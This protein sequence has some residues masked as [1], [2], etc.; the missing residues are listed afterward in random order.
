MGALSVNSKSLARFFAGSVLAVILAAAPIELSAKQPSVQDLSGLTASGAYLAARHAGRMR[1]AAV[2]AEFYRAALAHDPKNTDLLDR[3]FL[4][5]VIGGK[6]PEAVRLAKRVVRA[7]K[8]F[9][10]GYSYK[11]LVEDAKL[12]R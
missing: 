10:A 7:D 11:V 3:A 1:D 8:N 12:E 5:L 2:A 9:G 4:S 6:I